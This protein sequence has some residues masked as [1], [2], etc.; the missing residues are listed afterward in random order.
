VL[1]VGDE[2]ERLEGEMLARHT[3]GEVLEVKY[4]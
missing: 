4:A 1:E 2:G 3:R